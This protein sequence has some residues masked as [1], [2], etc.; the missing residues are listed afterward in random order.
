MNK[1]LSVCLA[2][3]CLLLPARS[4]NAQTTT[5]DSE[6]SAFLTLINN[7]RAQNGVGPLQV[8]VAL[9]QSSQWMSSDMAA[10]NYFSHTDSLG[11]DPFSR[12]AAFGYS[13]APAG[14]NIAAGYSDAQNTFTQWQTACDPD[15]SGACTY[16]HNKNML[17]GSYKVMGIGRAYNASSTYRW[18]WTTDFGGV[19]DQTLGSTTPPS[20]APT[21]GS[22]TATPLTISAGQQVT[23]AWSVS[24]ASSVSINNG[25]GDVTYLTSKT[26][27]P[28]ATTQY[29]LTATN[30]NGTKTASVT[31]TV[32]TPTTTP[33]PSTSSISMWPSTSYPTM[34]LS[35]GGP[36]E[37]GVKFRSD[38]AGKITGIRF[39]KLSSDT[40]VHTGSLWSTDG[41]L[42]AT[43]T[44]TSETAN[45][46]QTL[47]F[48]SP[49]AISANTTYVASYHTNSGVASAGFELQ[50]RGQ[51]NPPLHAL[52][53]GVDGYNGVY[54][55]GGGG[56]YPSQGTAGYNFWVDV[57]FTR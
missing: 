26:V 36:L 18:Y 50:S 4:G 15:A 19:V 10:K 3:G 43:G 52:Q 46:W 56:S 42:L 9:Q 57:V 39:Y 20:P 55:F 23:L 24:G 29:T 25:V 1:T 51:D 16:A 37:L 28:T 13:Y 38:V 21:I 12:M 44:F 14:E 8:S 11:R 34:Y 54:V 41:R 31:V 45:G 47:T 35:A 5:L 32:N 53:T 22:F 17:N 7:Y 49:V 33:P 40:G 6:Q 2:L 48:A 27:A 30:A